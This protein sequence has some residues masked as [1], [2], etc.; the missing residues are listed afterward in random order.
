MAAPCGD[1]IGFPVGGRVQDAPPVTVGLTNL[2]SQAIEAPFGPDLGADGFIRV[3]E[4]VDIAD[5]IPA[6]LVETRI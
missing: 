6:V 3:D 4:F 5:A 1:W 2:P